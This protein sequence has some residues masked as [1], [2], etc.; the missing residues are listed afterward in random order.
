MKAVLFIC[1]VVLIGVPLLFR[2]EH[3]SMP[4]SARQV[5][6][7][8]PHNEQIRYEFAQAFDRWH[9]DHYGERA[10]VIYNVPG[11]TS[12]IRKML[13]AQFT[14]AIEG[15]K[16][17]GGDADLVFGG[18]SF[19]HGRLKRGVRI[20]VEGTERYEPITAPVAFSD[21]WLAATF[22]E[23]RVGEDPLYDPEKHWFGTVLS[24][25]GIV[26]NRDALAQLN[27][28]E[29]RSWADVC[30]PA[31]QGW[32]AL[33]NPNQSGSV[34]TSF[35]AI[36]KRNGWEQGWRLLRRAGANARYFSG[37][38]LKPPID[39]SQGNA[40][41]GI[42]IDF[43]GRVQ[44]QSMREAGNPNR[45]NYVDPMDGRMIDVDPIS[46]LRNAPNQEMAQRFIEFCLSEPGQALWQLPRRPGDTQ[47][48]LGPRRFE[49]R[50]LP[51]A[52][53]MY[54]KYFDRFIDRVNPY[55][56]ATPLE[57]PNPHFRD[58]IAPMFAAMVM[59]NHHELKEAWKAIASTPGFS[60]SSGLMSADEATDP[61]LKQMLTLLDAM[62]QI[63]GPDGV[64]Y[65]MSDVD[66][67]ATVRTGWLRGGW[68]GR[69]LWSEHA[70]PAD[71]M[72][73]QWGEFFRGNYRQ[74]V[75]LSKQPAQN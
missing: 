44:E 64:A 47:E 41:V 23:N 43:L 50:R 45:I 30:D 14:A 11:G 31:F 57:H 69:G 42:C 54:E 73:R 67:L 27:C 24:G 22:G 37:S 65:S 12:E 19:E 61:A 53:F 60:T 68:S 15:G 33:V 62:P 2:P 52:R 35:E 49:L 40:A 28:A 75:R 51:I 16:E 18:G 71:E 46:M 10:H 4:G 20:I 25:F 36:L 21:E 8:T 72:R 74:I 6:V 9:Q 32:V 7:I 3:H 58:F 17:P 5:I 39:V 66:S 63:A 70:T 59:D 1:L 38:S 34:A 29:P 55:E 26:Y 48:G 13:E 56:L